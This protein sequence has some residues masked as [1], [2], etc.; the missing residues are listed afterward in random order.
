MIKIPLKKRFKKLTTKASA[1]VKSLSAKT[2]LKTLST[3]FDSEPELDARDPDEFRRFSNRFA[4]SSSRFLEAFES[5]PPPD[6]RIEGDS[7]LSAERKSSV[8]S[9]TVCL[10]NRLIFGSTQFLLIGSW[11]TFAWLSAPPLLTNPEFWLEYS[12]GRN[13]F[14]DSTKKLVASCEFGA[15]LFGLRVPWS[16]NHILFLFKSLSMSKSL[17]FCSTMGWSSVFSSCKFLVVD[18]RRP[19]DEENMTLCR[20]SFAKLLVFS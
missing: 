3:K 16:F 11:F 6:P 10:G 13:L 7:L 5:D 20:Y 4:C 14:F 9:T 15:F 18:L 19:W 8:T 12:A 1:L 2:P 17:S